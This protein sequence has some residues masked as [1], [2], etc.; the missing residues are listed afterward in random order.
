MRAALIAG[1]AAAERLMVDQVEIHRVTEVGP[2]PLTGQDRSTRELVYAGKAKVQTY[3][4]HESPAEVSGHEATIQRYSL[5]IP[6]A[7]YYPNVGDHVVIVSTVFDP[8]LNG[9][10]YRITAPYFKTMATA[11]RMHIEEIAS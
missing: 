5:H 4:A 6:V 9:N 7:S 3:E 2:D 11:Y 1:R 8:H 10:E